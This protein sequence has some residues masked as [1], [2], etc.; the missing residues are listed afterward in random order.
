VRLT[1]EK[2]W[3]PCGVCGSLDLRVMFCAARSGN[4]VVRC[5]RC[6]LV[7]YNP[8]PGEAAV[9]ALYSEGYFIQEYPS[10]AARDSLALAHR[11]LA[12]LEHDVLGRVLVDVGC[13]VGWFVMAARQRGWQ[14]IGVDPSPAAVRAAG[15]KGIPVFHANLSDLSPPGVP[16]A[17]VLTMWDV[18][19]HL[20]NPVEGLRHAK[21]WLREGGLIAIQTQNVSGLAFA[22]MRH[23][24]GQFVDAHLYHFSSQTLRMALQTAG[25]ECVHIQAA[26]T[27]CGDRPEAHAALEPRDRRRRAVRERVSALYD[28]MLVWLGYEPFDI[29]VATARR[30]VR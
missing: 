18:L 8:R 12:R 7:F 9:K 3:I 2:V 23:R 15:E 20:T 17:D 26:A 16:P 27:F 25:Y 29:M 6:G 22:R 4:Q 19:E 1:D 21:A 30:P 28:R 11:R 13:G 5:R 10:E 14:A 24:W